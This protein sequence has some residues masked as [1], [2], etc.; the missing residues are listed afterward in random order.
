MGGIQTQAID[1]KRAGPA[2]SVVLTLQYG[3]SEKPRR[4]QHGVSDD[5]PTNPDRP[6]AG[7][8]RGDC[9]GNG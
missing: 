2:P 1:S 7:D 3:S 5:M 9:T 8:R 4:C 6:I